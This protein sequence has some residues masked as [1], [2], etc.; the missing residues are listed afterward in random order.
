MTN[1][2]IIWEIETIPDLQG[3]AAA[4]YL[5]GKSDAEIK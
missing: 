1:H 4:N 3:F 2:V 5:A